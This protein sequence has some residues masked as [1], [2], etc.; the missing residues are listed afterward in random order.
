MNESQSAERP[1]AHAH[2]TIAKARS[3]DAAFVLAGCY[4]FM[5]AIERPPRSTVALL[6]REGYLEYF[7]DHR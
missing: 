1:A 7:L 2:S 5:S 3:S 4:R 6:R